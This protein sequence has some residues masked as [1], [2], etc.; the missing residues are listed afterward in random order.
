MNN[1]SSNSLPKISVVIPTKDRADYLRV[2]LNSLDQQSYQGKLEVFVVDDTDSG[3]PATKAIAEEFAVNYAV[4]PNPGGLN[5]ARN[6]GVHRSQG[7]VVLFLDDDIEAFPNLLSELGKA[8][9]EDPKSSIFAGRIVPK[10]EG[11]PLNF[12]ERREPPV[13][14][15]DLA[16]DTET[17]EFAWG[18]NM[19][20]RREAFSHYGLFDEQIHGCGD[21]EDWQR[22]AKQNGAKVSYLHTAA[23]TH[24]RNAED[25]KLLNLAKGAYRRGGNAYTYDLHCDKAPPLKTEL[26]NLLGCIKHTVTRRCAGGLIETAHTVGRL[27]RRF[28]G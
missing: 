21:E 22:T 6:Y 14:E 7:E 24:R 12:C 23:V 3:D 2:T 16:E 10:L 19:A 1:S 9:K 28:H 5:T 20:I 26:H 8:V 15:L 27:S 17:T 25:S 18:A 4:T 13:T 11:R